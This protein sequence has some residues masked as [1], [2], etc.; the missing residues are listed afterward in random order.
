MLWHELKSSAAVCNAL[1]GRGV[2]LLGMRA[3][4]WISAD[5]VGL[6]QRWATS[7]PQKGATG[8]Q[9]VCFTAV[10]VALNVACWVSDARFAE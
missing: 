9:S 6:C 8:D 2:E 3:L 5:F 4:P 7:S 1:F 10:F